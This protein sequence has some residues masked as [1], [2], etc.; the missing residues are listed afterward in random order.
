MKN[1]V[2]IDR[3]NESKLFISL[4]KLAISRTRMLV[5]QLREEAK[6]NRIPISQVW[7]KKWSDSW[8]DAVKWL[9]IDGQL[10]S[11]IWLIMLSAIADVGDMRPSFNL[12]QTCFLSANLHFRQPNFSHPVPIQILSFPS[13]FCH[14]LIKKLTNKNRYIYNRKDEIIHDLSEMTLGKVWNSGGGA[15]PKLPLPSY[16]LESRTRKGF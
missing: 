3:L 15:R 8:D 9:K 1:R 4:A 10:L 11:Y 16:V 7:W 5:E 12:P 6:L 2:E 14:M 13:I